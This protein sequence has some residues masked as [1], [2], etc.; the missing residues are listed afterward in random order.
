MKQEPA[1]GWDMIRPPVFR[2]GNFEAAGFALPAALCY[3][4]RTLYLNDNEA[5]TG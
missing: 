5:I 3:T 4:E 1:D 2:R